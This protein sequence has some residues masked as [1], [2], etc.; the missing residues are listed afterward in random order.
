[1]V[2]S[3]LYHAVDSC[4]EAE[5]GASRAIRAIPKTSGFRKGGRTGLVPLQKLGFWNSAA[6]WI[7]RL[8][9]L[10]RNDLNR[11]QVLSRRWARFGTA[12]TV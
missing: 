8:L 11:G 4:S 5:L 10:H 9:E 1:M 3:R 7:A 12:R 6:F 2:L